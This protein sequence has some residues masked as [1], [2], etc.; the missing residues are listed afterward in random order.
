MAMR[1]YRFFTRA[2]Q[3]I[4]LQREKVVTLQRCPAT[5]A[6]VRYR[7]DPADI[8]VGETIV[9]NERRVRVNG[10]GMTRDWPLE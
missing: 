6:R 2:G 3:L 8:D 9:F 7:K 4:Y 5:G 10:L 1:A